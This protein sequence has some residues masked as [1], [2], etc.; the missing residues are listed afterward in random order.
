MSWVG[1]LLS[2]CIAALPSTQT[3]S[4]S[5]PVAPSEAAV[6]PRETPVAPRFVLDP[7]ADTAVISLSAGFGLLSQAIIST[8]EISPQAPGDP[9]VL[10]GIDRGVAT[11]DKV[12]EGSRVLS[13]VLVSSAFGY[14]LLD[15]VLTAS[16]DRR[17]ERAVTV[18]VI[19]LETIAVNLAVG[20]LSKIAV[21]RPRPLS[22]QAV[23]QGTPLE[24]TDSSLSFYSMHTAF[25]AS[26]GA[27]ATYLA[28]ERGGDV[29]PW[30]VLGAS[31]VITA[32][33]GVNRVLARAHFPTDVVAGALAGAG[34][35][36]LV[37][38]LHR[39]RTVSLSLGPGPGDAGLALAGRF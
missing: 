24:D 33:V 3:S 15:T 7:V 29:E 19:Y 38:H 20:N 8:G 12:G 25:T 37:P 36:V 26:L 4:A 14:A 23:R 27:T 31:T 6:A 5:A 21:R 13:D 32:A 16:L 22:Y 39:S 2:G 28:F 9:S 17:T 1:L 34:L 30:V 35:G 11:S 10:L 18:G